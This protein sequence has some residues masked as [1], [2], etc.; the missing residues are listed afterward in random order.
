MGWPRALVLTAAWLKRPAQ[1]LQRYWRQSQDTLASKERI[2]KPCPAYL[3]GHLSLLGCRLAEAAIDTGICAKSVSEK[4]GNRTTSGPR[5]Y[6]ILGQFMPDIRG[7]WPGV[8]E[9]EVD[10]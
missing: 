7:L 5:Y 4:E 10:L 9:S 8:A 2:L 1:H 6:L 3:A